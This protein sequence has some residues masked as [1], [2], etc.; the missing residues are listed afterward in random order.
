MSAVFDAIATAW[1]WLWDNMI[2]VNM[3]LAIVI[4]FFER[5][6]PRAVWAWLLVLYFLPG[7]GFLMYLILGQNMNK[8]R[9]FRIKEIEDVVNSEIRKQSEEVKNEQITSGM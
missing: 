9:M 7:I 6:E 8:D 5:R 1:C 3:I 4:V 2:Y